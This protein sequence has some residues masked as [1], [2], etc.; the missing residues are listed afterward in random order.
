MRV[1]LGAGTHVVNEVSSR[2]SDYLGDPQMWLPSLDHQLAFP[3][4]R[5]RGGGDG[6][7]LRTRSR[8]STSEGE[9]GAHHEE[10]RVGLIDHRAG[11][12]EFHFIVAFAGS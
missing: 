12:R 1:C 8:A 3:Q 2:V 9:V 11:D 10:L 4:A 7:P 5:G 6:K